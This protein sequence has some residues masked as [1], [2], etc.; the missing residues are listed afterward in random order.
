MACSSLLSL[1]RDI[2]I[3]LPDYIHNIEDYT[4]ISSTCT[5][6]RDCMGTASPSNILRL[7]TAQ[8]T[9]F[10]RPSPHFLVTA[11]AKEL[12]YWARESEANEDELAHRLE[13]GV[14]GLLNL[15]L[16]HCGLTMER[17][18]QLHL[19][20]FSIINPVTDLIDK[21]VGSQWYSTPNFWD[22]G[23]DDAYTIHA[24]PPATL[25]HLALY[26]EL[27]GPDF[28]IFLDPAD[29]SPRRLSVDT[30][31]EFVKYCVP[32]WATSACQDSASG[33]IMP[34]GQIDPRRAVKHTGPYA[35]GAEQVRDDNNI[36]LVWVIQSS[37][38]KPRWRAMRA[39]AGVI[40]FQANFRDEWWYNPDGE[41]NW[42][43]RMLEAVIIC[44]GLEGLGMIRPDLRDA[45][46]ARVRV[47]REKIAVL[48]QEPKWTKVGDQATLEY[49]FLLGDLRIC[50][51][52]F[53]CGT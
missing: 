19:Q 20:R 30:R 27:F 12:G 10:F 22:G 11:T 23:V 49:P 46:A 28:N 50:G 31:L 53:V 9:T 34:D 18:R 41:Q 51:S 42:R 13:D 15:A 43:Q 39:R 45:W 5:L 24:D 38:W 40:D 6:L 37:H 7:A 14:D 36:A 17:I 16:K 21:C 35:T 29:Q 1:P 25:F 32:D 47:W 4:N 44:Q 33:V 52:G 3:L 8:S 26:G 48:E 2:L